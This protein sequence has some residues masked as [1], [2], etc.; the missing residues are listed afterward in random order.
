MEIVELP[1]LDKYNSDAERRARFNYARY[2]MWILACLI[3]IG[4]LFFISTL[5]SSI[6]TSIILPIIIMG[7]VVAMLYGI[8]MYTI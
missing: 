1:T 5:D 3:I 2:Y 4:N 8:E 6:K 7:A